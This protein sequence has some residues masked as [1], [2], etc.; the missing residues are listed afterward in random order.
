VSLSVSARSVKG[1]WIRHVPHKADLLGRASTPT[2]GRWQR[3]STVGGLYLAD[4]PDTATAEWYRVLAELG[5]SPQENV[6]YDQHRWRVNLELADLSDAERLCAVD[7]DMPRPSR[8]TWQ[9]YQQVGEQ[10]W[11]EGWTGLIAPSAARPESLIVCVFTHTWAP[12]KCTPLDASTVSAVPPRPR[13][14][15][16]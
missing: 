7:L 4:T 3:G 16:T 15:T 11:R 12:G 1:A 13:G 10:L 9:P 6:P 2:D 5:L 14:L 8:R